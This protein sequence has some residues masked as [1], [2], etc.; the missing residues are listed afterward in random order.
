[1]LVDIF[2]A[3]H[4]LCRTQ[5]VSCFREVARRPVLLSL[6]DQVTLPNNGQYSPIVSWIVNHTSL[7]FHSSVT[8]HQFIFSNYFFYLGISLELF[9]A[10]TNTEYSTFHRWEWK[11]QPNNKKYNKITQLFK[12]HTSSRNYAILF[13]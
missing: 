1:M 4:K 11:C 2:L 8:V 6:D 7:S 12:N 10:N 13:T 9:F 5:S 3:L